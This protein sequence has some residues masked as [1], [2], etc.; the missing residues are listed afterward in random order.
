MNTGRAALLATGQ[1]LVIQ[2]WVPPPVLNGSR[3]RHWT[4]LRKEA[5]MVKDTVWASAKQAG[6]RYVGD[7]APRQKLTVTFVFP[8]HRRRDIDNLYARAKHLVD[9]IKPF[10]VDDDSEH[11]DLEVRAVVERG[12]KETRI[13]LRQA[14]GQP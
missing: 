12:M 9:G 11:L 1:S 5:Q 14:E 6:W 7:D 13:E 4:V 10:I 8:S 2:G 3:Q